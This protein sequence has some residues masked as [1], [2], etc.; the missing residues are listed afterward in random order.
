M[1]GGYSLNSHEAYC[2]QNMALA[3]MLGLRPLGNNVIIPAYRSLGKWCSTLL[4]EAKF[5]EY[6]LW[7]K[8]MCKFIYS[9]HPI[10]RL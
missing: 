5:N 6:T 1:Y 10:Y 7:I 8:Y 4:Y 2:I 9:Y 3:K